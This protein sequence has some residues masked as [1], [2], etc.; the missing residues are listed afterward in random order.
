MNYYLIENEAITQSA[1]FRFD[2][3]CLETEE[4]IVRGSDDKLYLESQWQ[5]TSQ[6]Q[7]FQSALAEIDKEKRKN[8]LQQE[9]AALDTKRIRAI[10]EPEVKNSET[11]ETWLE[12]Y[13]AQIMNLRSQIAE[14]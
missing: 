5:E 3:N 11:G 12:Y 1:D 9:I 13:T 4:Q 8:E 7:E 10:A 2:P 6:S 14:L